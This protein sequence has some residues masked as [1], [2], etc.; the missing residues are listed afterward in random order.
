MGPVAR[1]RLWSYAVASA[2]RGYWD[3][4]NQVLQSLMPFDDMRADVMAASTY[5]AWRRTQAPDAAGRLEALADRG[6]AIARLFL[7]YVHLDAGLPLQA[8]AALQAVLQSSDPQAREMALYLERHLSHHLNTS[9]L[10]P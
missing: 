9:P 1:R 3:E 6:H 4:S 5:Q 2:Q 7:G 8:I 10:S